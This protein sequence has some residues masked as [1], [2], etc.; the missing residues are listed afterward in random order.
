MPRIDTYDVFDT[1]SNAND[2]SE[3]VSIVFVVGL[4]CLII[5]VFSIA[6]FSSE[7][8]FKFLGDFLKDTITIFFGSI[9]FAIGGILTYIGILF[10]ANPIITIIVMILFLMTIC[11]CFN[12]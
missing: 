2:G 1:Y 3:I 4:L 8:K 11:S 9:F 10:K 12:S 5:I 7:N 6:F